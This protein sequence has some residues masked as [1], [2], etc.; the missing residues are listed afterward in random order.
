MLRLALILW[1][2]AS[3]AVAE[4]LRVASF[5]ASLSRSAP[6]QLIRAL[7]N[8]DDPQVAAVIGIVT[9][10]APDIILINE[11]DHDLDGIA[12]AAFQGRLKAAGL[13]LPH[14]Y[15]GATNTGLLTGLDLNGDGSATGP[16][17]A[18]GYGRFPGQYGMALLSRHPITSVRSFRTLVWRDQP[19]SLMPLEAVSEEAQPVLRLSSKSH[20]DARVE[21]PSG[22]L[23]LLASHPTPPV[24]DGPEDLNGRRNHDEILLWVRYLDGEPL[25]D[26]AGEVAGPPDNPLVVLGDLNADPF[27]GDSRRGALAA[28]LSHPRLQDP[29]PVSDGAVAAAARQGGV[30]D[31]HRGPAAQDTADWND[32]RG[33]GNLRAD[34]VLPSRELTVTGSGVYWPAPGEPGHAWIGDGRPVSSDHRLVW[35][36]ITFD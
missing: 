1:I 25:R 16:E 13:D 19:G 6:G 12:L 34:Y 22:P 7:E 33:P 31:D 11:F 35:V 5:N 3:P 21:T 27:D 30:N 15:A 32:R 29:E 24:F 28:L 10:I 26:D 23:H 14:A 17:D 9:E 4:S 8:R 20:W 36:D 18:F 2:G